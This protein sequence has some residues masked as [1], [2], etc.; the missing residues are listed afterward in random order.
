MRI[1]FFMI[2]P[3]GFGDRLAEDFVIAVVSLI[4]LMICQCSTPV[5]R[6]KAAS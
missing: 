3:Y 2:Q 6:A 4:E 5:A 1:T